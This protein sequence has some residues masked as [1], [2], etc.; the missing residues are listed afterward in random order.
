M[1]FSEREGYKKIK[2][3]QIESIDDELKV[4]IWNLIWKIYFRSVG[5]DV[6]Y[7]EAI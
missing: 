6:L 2:E 4:G 5:G 3:I 1:S 7:E